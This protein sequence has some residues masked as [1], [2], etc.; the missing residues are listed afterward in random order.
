MINIVDIKD[1]AEKTVVN[2]LSVLLLIIIF[3]GAVQLIAH[4]TGRIAPIADFVSEK[5]LLVLSGLL[6]A[7]LAAKF[8]YFIYSTVVIF[9]TGTTSEKVHIGSGV[10]CIMISGGFLLSLSNHLSD[11]PFLPISVF[12]P[13][14]FAL[15][16]EVS[17]MMGRPFAPW[18]T[19]EIA[20][21]VTMF[22][23]LLCGGGLIVEAHE[24]K[25]KIRQSATA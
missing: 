15:L 23:L 18:T 19:W 16:K 9:I 12:S 2:A 4:L 3:S 5:A 13:S 8:M 6:L 17:M 22:I 7:M 10:I 25:T 21:G 24:K 11:I 1:K 14:I 20:R